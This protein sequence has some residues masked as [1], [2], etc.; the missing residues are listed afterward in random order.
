MLKEKISKT[1]SS[2]ETVTLKSGQSFQ[3]LVD[4]KVI[5]E[6]VIPEGETFEISIIINGNS[7]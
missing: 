2:T 7:I 4:G 3:V 5:S 6:Y 1:I